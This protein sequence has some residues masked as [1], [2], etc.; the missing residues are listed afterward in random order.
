M[1]DL[2]VAH[3][4][5]VGGF[6]ASGR[7]RGVVNRLIIFQG[8]DANPFCLVGGEGG[9]TPS[10]PKLL[11]PPAGFEPATSGFRNR[12]TVQSAGALVL[13]LG[14]AFALT[15]W[16]ALEEA[17]LEREIVLRVVFV[18]SG[19]VVVVRLELP[20]AALLLERRVH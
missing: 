20:D 7:S 11:V 18:A 8:H 4:M 1:G 15:G 5:K 19:L 12:N 17:L 3:R 13:T 9:T 10:P 14:R 2:G 16:P 6:E